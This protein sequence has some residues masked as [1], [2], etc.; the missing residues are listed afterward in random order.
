[1]QRRI[2]RSVLDLQNLVSGALDVLGDGVA[3][4]GTE[5]Q[6]AQDQHVECSLQKLYAVG[7][8]LGHSRE[9]TLLGISLPGLYRSLTVTALFGGVSNARGYFT[10]GSENAYSVSPQAKMRYC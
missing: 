7:G 1:M 5:Q 3:M 10:C 4:R 9:S 8:L 6:R 2:E